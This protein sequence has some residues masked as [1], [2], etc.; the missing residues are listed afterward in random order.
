MR[1]RQIFRD[2]VLVHSEDWPV[3]RDEFVAEL[4]QLRWEAEMG[5][6][7]VNGVRVPTTREARGALLAEIDSASRVEDYQSVWVFGETVIP[8][9]VDSLRSLLDVVNSH[10]RACFAR[11]A[12]LLARSETETLDDLFDEM[13]RNWPGQE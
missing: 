13:Q 3:T 12:S 9:T 11:Q 4:A 6:T 8:V 10:V 7:L 5:G 1:K 2:S